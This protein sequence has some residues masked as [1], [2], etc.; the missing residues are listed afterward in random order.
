MIYFSYQK[1]VFFFIMAYMLALLTDILD[2]FFAR[3]M[4]KESIFGK[5]LDIVADNFIVL[6]LIISFYFLKKELLFS[7]KWHILFLF[8]YFVLVQLI[9]FIFMKGF[10]FMR[11]Y[12]ANIAAIIFPAVVIFSLFFES[13]NLIFL[14]II[15]ML[16]SLTEKLFLKMNTQETKSIFFNSSWKIRLW[17]LIVFAILVSVL[18]IILIIPNFDNRDKVCF[19]DGYCIY[20]DVKD[21]YEERALGLMFRETLNEN[22]GMLF[23]FEELSTSPFWMKNMKIP[24]DII[25][26]S[27]DK[28]IVSISTNAIPCNKP[29]NECELYY[30]EAPYLYVVETK[31]GFSERHNLEKGQNVLFSLT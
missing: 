17:F 28:K 1:D 20:V 11:T 24:I 27:A 2:G 30:S 8:S 5:K 16:Y 6:C 22:E 15:I 19:S 23:I 25:F 9:S 10:T 31:A 18:F 29:D 3:K 4:K 14:Y 7:Y 21:T 26:I 13:K 12:A